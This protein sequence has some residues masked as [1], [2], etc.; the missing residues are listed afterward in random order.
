MPG[1]IF[2]MITS[3]R[4]WASPK[5]RHMPAYS[6]LKSSPSTVSICSPYPASVR[7]RSYPA[8][9]CWG[10]PPMV[11]LLSSIR[12]LTASSLPTAR[13]AA[14]ALSPS[15]WLPSLPSTTT[16]LPGLAMAT[17]L[18]NAHMWPSR[19]LLYSM[20]GVSIFSGWPGRP[21]SYSR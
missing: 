21:W 4:G 20:P 18:Q 2:R 6:E 17:P 16:C 15:I 14:S 9:Y 13:R 7:L 5:V 19:P 10:W 1:A 3:A 12:I 8:M 11:T